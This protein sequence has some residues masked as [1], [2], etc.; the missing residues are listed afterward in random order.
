MTQM[1]VAPKAAKLDWPPSR[2]QRPS[3]QWSDIWRAPLHDFPIRDEILYQF[4]P[5]SPEMDVLEIGP[6]CGF[7]AVRLARHVQHLTSLDIGKGTIQSLQEG[8]GGI[9]NL[10]FVCAD[11]CT[12]E[13]PKLHPARFDAAFGLA[14]FD[15]LPDPGTCL[16]NLGAL[17]RPG[18]R[19]LLQFP[20]Y[21]PPKGR[22][23]TSF[24]N[25]DEIDRLMA[26]AAFESWETFALT[27]RPYAGLIYGNLYDAPL[28][29]LRRLRRGYSEQRP[30]SYDG[31]WTFQRTSRLNRYKWFVHSALGF[32]AFL[33]RLGGDCFQLRR[34]SGEIL[35]NNLLL[36]G[37]R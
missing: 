11:V 15:L 9:P 20:N 28:Q 14:V 10:K 25:S 19:L 36:L 12:P 13:L 23:I 3:F 35:N 17:L 6:G 16:K 31:T 24:K 7:T 33:I 26:A 29:A 4:L 27:L 21:P 5:L 8:L 22:G 2:K 37:Q 32:L 1:I 30:L 34:L 18:G